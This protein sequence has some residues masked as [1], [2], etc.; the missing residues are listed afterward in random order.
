MWRFRVLLGNVWEIGTPRKLRGN[1]VVCDDSP[2]IRTQRITTSQ[3]E[4]SME[5]PRLGDGNR[6]VR[7]A[8][9]IFLQSFE[10][11]AIGSF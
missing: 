1:S 4:T 3:H 8:T 7:C 10:E 6:K 2:K 9:E 5:I 11:V